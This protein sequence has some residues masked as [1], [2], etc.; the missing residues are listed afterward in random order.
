MSHCDWEVCG[1]LSRVTWQVIIIQAASLSS[2][3][4]IHPVVTIQQFA[5]AT[6]AEIN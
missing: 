6:L 3:S 5:D 2:A 4:A 1:C